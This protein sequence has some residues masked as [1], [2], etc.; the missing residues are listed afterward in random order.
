MTQKKRR[1]VKPA[2]KLTM[3]DNSRP[4]VKVKPHRPPQVGKCTSCGWTAWLYG[5]N[6]PRLCAT[7]NTAY[8]REYWAKLVPGRTAL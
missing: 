5:H 7:C 2:V 4:K 8:W 1:A 6:R 3:K